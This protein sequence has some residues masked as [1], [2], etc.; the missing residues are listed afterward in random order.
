MKF[1]LIDEGYKAEVIR[2]C[3]NSKSFN[4]FIILSKIKNL[5]KFLSTEKGINFMKAFKRLNSIVD[6]TVNNYEL[7]HSL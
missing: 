2:S 1:F 7:D 3:L 5:T 6:N 4:P